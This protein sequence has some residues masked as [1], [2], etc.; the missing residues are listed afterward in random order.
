M[1]KLYDEIRAQQAF[2]RLAY[3]KES[4]DCSV[5]A[6][7]VACVAPYDIAHAAMAFA[8]RQ[9]SGTATGKMI[10]TA[11]RSLGCVMYG[12]EVE[13]KTLRTLCR[14]LKAEPGN[15]MAVTCNHVVGFYKGE[16]IDWSR[17]TL[18]RIKAVVL[19]EKQNEKG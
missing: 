5:R 14:E 16:C 18:A 3:N 8:G 12:I 9:P 13:S 1:S 17:D 10:D 15:Y 6:L 2:Y 11:A 19:V 4:H 7:A